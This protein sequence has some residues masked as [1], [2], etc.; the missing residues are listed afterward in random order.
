MQTTWILVCDASRARLFATEGREGEWQLL[1]ELS[2]PLSR[3]HNTDLTTDRSGVTQSG[4]SARTG[5]RG[6]STRAYEPTTYPKE[7]EAQHFAQLLAGALDEGRV[8]GA[9]ERLVLVA[10]PHFLGLLRAELSGPLAKLVVAS[11][12]K[13]YTQEQARALPGRL[14]EYVFEAAGA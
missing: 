7:A 9:F 13:D 14:E 4:S 6:E 2:H 8:R 3:T 10:P 1:R 5:F 12:D 11:L